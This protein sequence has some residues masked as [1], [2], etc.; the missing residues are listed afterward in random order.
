MPDV[1]AKPATKP[2]QCL[3]NRT[4]S[5]SSDSI[6]RTSTPLSSAS[7]DASLEELFATSIRQALP[8]TPSRY[9]KTPASEPTS[10]TEKPQSAGILEPLRR[11][12]Y[13]DKAPLAQVWAVCR[14]LLDQRSEIRKLNLA[15]EDDQRLRD[16]IF[17][18]ILLSIT[19]SQPDGSAELGL[20][21]PSDLVSLY[22]QN[23]LM[24]Y[25]WDSI[26]WT[27]LGSF[28]RLRYNISSNAANQTDKLVEQLL[29]LW[30]IFISKY[31]NS[32]TGEVSPSSTSRFLD[33]KFLSA[34][35]KHP[36]HGFDQKFADVATAAALTHVC[37][38]Y[39]PKNSRPNSKWTLETVRTVKTITN[40]ARDIRYTKLDRR[41]AT[42]RLLDEGLDPAFISH[43]LS[44]WHRSESLRSA[45]PT[46]SNLLSQQNGLLSEQPFEQILLQLQDHKQQ[47]LN[48][49]VDLGSSS[50]EIRTDP[51]K[52]ERIS[53][54]TN[55]S[56]EAS[57]PVRYSQKEVGK[58]V[59]DLEKATEHFNLKQ[60]SAIWKD[61]ETRISF[62]DV[63]KRHLETLFARFLSSFWT[64]RLHDQAVHVWNKMISFDIQ[65]NQRHWNAMLSGC[66]K[67][68]DYASLQYLWTKMLTAGVQPDQICW[69]I[70]IEGLIV[71]GHHEHA[72]QALGELGRLW[73]KRARQ[74]AIENDQSSTNTAELSQK[75]EAV[76]NDPNLPD[77][78]LINSTINA[79]V[80]TRRLDLCVP[81]L[82]WA[83]SHA[84][85]LDT[86]IFNVLLRP[87]V[88][89][90]DDSTIQALLTSMS[91]HNCEPDIFTFNL[92]LNG[93]LRNP[94]SSFSAKTPEAQEAVVLKFLEDMENHGFKADWHTYG[95]ILDRLLCVK[96]PNLTAARAVL[97]YMNESN[98]KPSAHIY[99]IL[100]GHYFKQ[101]PPNLAAVDATWNQIRSTKASVDHVFYNQIVEGYAKC[102]ELEPM[103]Y[104][105]RIAGKEAKSPTW[106]VLFHVLECVVNAREWGLVE[107]LVKD[108]GDPNGVRKY[109]AGMGTLSGRRWE[110]EFWALVESVRGMIGTESLQA[111]PIS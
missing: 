42:S 105:L 24:R 61:F 102:G 83:R 71:C 1:P 35:P 78:S 14:Q 74:K 50:T 3:S 5:K 21:S 15:S 49:D 40:L 44:K 66:V 6:D 81:V 89:L 33:S 104:F 84:I 48:V 85:V 54:P 65:P 18:D 87:A 23:R 98:V 57:V 52:V 2:D 56:R 27:L 11:S 108:V 77:V 103:F 111:S 45:L 91:Q 51:R 47:F 58:T 30:T 63:H 62:T 29:A 86:A 79:L 92:I 12:L 96:P 53:A 73:R 64:L 22:I 76:K 55:I 17:H 101:D 38:E 37:L 109:A 90:G 80:S 4:L 94:N 9:S 106:R 34:F 75:E 19:K 36:R 67:A 41:R 95:T 70:W 82:T 93:L 59:K 10:S 46:K 88:R 13:E 32:E 72:L 110:T 16:G 39:P 60:V 100:V 68:R 99:T 97:Q 20:P 8:S 26:L 107:E 7:R 25:W 43:I 31:G 28:F 69:A